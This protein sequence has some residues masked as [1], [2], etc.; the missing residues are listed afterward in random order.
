MAE[1]LTDEQIESYRKRTMKPAGLLSADRHCLSCEDCRARLTQSGKLPAAFRNLKQNLHTAARAGPEHLEYELL[2]AYID[3][4]ANEL[5][6]EIVESHIELC[7]D[8]AG[9]LEELQAFAAMLEA[10]S[11][12]KDRQPEKASPWQRLLSLI[13]SPGESA[14][15]GGATAGFRLAGAAALVLLIAAA[16]VFVVYRVLNSNS[17]QLASRNANQSLPPNQ[18]ENLN[19]NQQPSNP[20]VAQSNQ[21]QNE[22]NKNIQPPQPPKPTSVFA[23]LVP[24]NIS[25]GGGDDKST[26]RISPDIGFVDLKVEVQDSD[27]KSFTAQLQKIGGATRNLKTAVARNGVVSF[28]VA[29]SV[30][31]AGQYYM[32]IFRLPRDPDDSGLETAFKVEKVQ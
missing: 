19:T 15:A 25:R 11:V 5:D 3:K 28:R 17:G 18:N 31:N 13:G 10:P 2:E 29:T 14:Q 24:L 8:C 21:N 20:T 12:A 30:L 9:E 23:F 32:K 4:R 7:A 6:R 27:G 26:L 16:S 1:H 22:A